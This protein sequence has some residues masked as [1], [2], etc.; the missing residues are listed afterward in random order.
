MMLDNIN[1]VNNH[2]EKEAHAH[3]S[4]NQE[5]VINSLIYITCMLTRSKV[6]DLKAGVKTGESL[7]ND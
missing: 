7:Q 3:K 5:I 6:L 4:K 1:S 2:V